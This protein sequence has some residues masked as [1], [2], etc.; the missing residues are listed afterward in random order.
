LRCGFLGRGS[1]CYI[2]HQRSPRTRAPSRLRAPSRTFAPSHTFAHLRT[3]ASAVEPPSRPGPASSQLISLLLHWE[4]A[5]NFKRFE[6]GALFRTD[7]RL[8]FDP[9][10][11]PLLGMG[12]NR[13]DED[14]NRNGAALVN[15]RRTTG[16]GS[17]LPALDGLPGILVSTTG[18][19]VPSLSVRHYRKSPTP[20]VLTSIH[21]VLPRQLKYV[22]AIGD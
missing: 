7:T 14:G 15:S 19:P 6:Y 2:A 21:G 18:A 5:R 17:R 11:R 10:F 22:K 9:K 12:I 13:S 20:P 8:S 4:G 3:P 1:T 16:R